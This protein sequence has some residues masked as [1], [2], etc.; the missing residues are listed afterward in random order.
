[1]KNT[2]QMPG[3]GFVLLVFLGVIYFASAAVVISFPS[4]L[5]LIRTEA[6]NDVILPALKGTENLIYLN[7]LLPLAIAVYYSWPVLKACQKKD[8]LEPS[9]LAKRRVLNAPLMLG[10]IMMLG[11]VIQIMVFIIGGF[12][13]GVTFHF[14]PTE[15]FIKT[16]IFSGMM[17]FIIAYYFLE[18]IIRKSFIPAFFPEGDLEKCDG[19]II[20]SVRSRFFIYFFAVS[21]IPLSLFLAVIEARVPYGILDVYFK[22]GVLVIV[23]LSLGTFLTYLVSR[24][25]QVPLVQMK[26]ATGEIRGGN[27]LVSVAV[28]SNDEVGNLGEGLNEMTEGLKE[29]EFIKDTFGRMVG[30]RVRD[31]LL[32]GKLELGGEMREA[33]ILFADIRGFTAMSEKMEPEKV[34]E[35]LNRYFERMSR[36]IFT[37]GGV[38]DKY[39]GDAMMAV[40]GPPFMLENHAV[41]AVKAAVQMRGERAVLNEELLAD[42]F[43]SIEAGIGIHMGKVL[44]G[45]IGSS[46]RMEYTVI[47]DAV[48]VAARIEDLSKELNQ[49]ILLSQETVEQL[50]KNFKTNYLGSISVRGKELPVNVYCL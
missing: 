1:L 45:N 46:A 33:T 3:P 32:N 47:G 49:D 6:H 10:L 11:W 4:W 14:E 19:T 25:Y 50:G 26:E 38:V 20:L 28:V 44:A 22:S 36:C 2:R 41:A 5:P 42:G 29:K 15:S 34:V 27:Y 8:K 9:C 40:F 12:V 18:F 24:A 48:N 39:I 23:F 13:N 31:H 37:Q 30:P 17:C 21:V 16:Q 7:F 35:M 43:P